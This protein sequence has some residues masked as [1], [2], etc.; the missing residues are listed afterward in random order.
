MEKVKS[1]HFLSVMRDKVSLVGGDSLKFFFKWHEGNWSC[2]DWQ[3][4]MSLTFL[5]F[6]HSSLNHQIN[7]C[8]QNRKCFRYDWLHKWKK[9]WVREKEKLILVC[10]RGMF[11]FTSK[12]I[13]CLQ[14]SANLQCLMFFIA[15]FPNLPTKIYGLIGW[16]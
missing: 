4:Y 8:L 11:G 10:Q 16:H 1:C 3:D 2:C 6:S 9:N 12:H 7:N 15:E 5:L 14:H 13:R